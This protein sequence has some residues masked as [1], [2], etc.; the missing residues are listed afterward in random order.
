MTN[1]ATASR[2]LLRLRQTVNLL[3]KKPTIESHALRTFHYS[4]HGYGIAGPVP[5]AHIGLWGDIADPG[6]MAYDQDVRDVP[7]VR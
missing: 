7:K 6:R 1:Y 4:Y 2:A 3:A 5:G